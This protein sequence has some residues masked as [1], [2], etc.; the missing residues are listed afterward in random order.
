[1]SQLHSF[2]WDKQSNLSIRDRVECFCIFGILGLDIFGILGL[3]IFGILGLDT[4]TTSS[5]TRI[6][7]GKKQR[8]E[9]VILP[10]SLESFVSALYRITVDYREK[11]S[12]SNQIYMRY[13]KSKYYIS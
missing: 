13:W 12:S 1:M 8:K 10:T 3:D 9:L 4:L 7:Y 11:K 2:A 5:V 6:I